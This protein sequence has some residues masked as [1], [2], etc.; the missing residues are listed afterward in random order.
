MPKR[1]TFVLCD[2]SVINSYGFR[3]NVDGIN[4]D[5]FKTNPVMLYG[6]DS[7]NLDSVIGRWE[8][9][10]VEG[11]KLMADAVFDVDTEKGKDV[12]GRVERGFLRGCSMGLR[13]TKFVE[14][15]DED[16]AEMSE[17]V[18]ASICAIPSDSNAVRLYDDN[19]KVITLEEM[20]LSFNNP[21]NNQEPMK[22]EPEQSENTDSRI[23]TLEAQ[24]QQRDTEIAQLKATISEMKK[25]SVE[26]FLTAAVKDGK[27]TEGEKEGFAKLATTDFDTVKSIIESKPAK[28]SASLKSMELKHASSSSEDGREKWTY[29]EWMKKD[30]EGL[31]SM[32]ANDPERFSELQKTI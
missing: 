29:L 19:N 16:V 1:Y 7:W 23:V 12:A 31:K 4:L 21:N 22:K 32:K 26:S 14:Y 5:R 28:A 9:I 20:K 8:N 15:E 13:I 6:H 11:G 10:R 2:G 25:E 27:I 3:T 24:V 18:E 30:P 17:L